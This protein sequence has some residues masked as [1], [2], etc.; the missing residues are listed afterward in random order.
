MRPMIANSCKEGV[1]R[2]RTKQLT[3]Y[4]SCKGDDLSCPAPPAQ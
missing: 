3:L 4:L 2:E 1:T